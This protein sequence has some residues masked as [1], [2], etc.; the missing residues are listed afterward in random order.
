L[1]CKQILTQINGAGKWVGRLKLE[2][3]RISPGVYLMAIV[4]SRSR[5]TSDLAEI[6]KARAWCLPRGEST[7]RWAV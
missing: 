5:L 6:G 3:K 1:D 2:I 7:T 4:F